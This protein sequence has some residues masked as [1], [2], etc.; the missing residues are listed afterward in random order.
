MERYQNS[1][2]NKNTSKA[3]CWIKSTYHENGA[4]IERSMWVV[5]CWNGP[6]EFT[7]I[8]TLRSKSLYKHTSNSQ[9]HNQNNDNNN[10]NKNKARTLSELIEFKATV[11]SH[12]IIRKIL[13][14]DYQFWPSL[15]YIQPNEELLLYTLVNNRVFIRLYC[16]LLLCYFNKM[17]IV[18]SQLWSDIY[19]FILSF[20][21]MLF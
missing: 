16:H 2:H 12:S 9:N 20:T 15:I 5:F 21:Y 14:D 11:V 7:H 3:C 10:N 18:T 17:L 8:V 19:L 4:V 1:R 6:I 13:P